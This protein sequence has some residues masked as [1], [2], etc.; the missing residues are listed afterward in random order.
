MVGLGTIVGQM[1]DKMTARRLQLSPF[2]A[3]FVNF[4]SG[5]VG[6]GSARSPN[7]GLARN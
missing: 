3:N 5:L 7:A 2:E 1:A 4:R 6:R